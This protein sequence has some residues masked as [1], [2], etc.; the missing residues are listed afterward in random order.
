[1]MRHFIDFLNRVSSDARGLSN[2]IYQEDEGPPVYQDDTTVD[3]P[4]YSDGE[5]HPPAYPLEVILL[6]MT[7]YQRR[8]WWASSVPREVLIAQLMMEFDHFP[9]D[10]DEG[11]PMM[12][13]EAAVEADAR[14][15]NALRWLAEEAA[16][17][18]PQEP[19]EDDALAPGEHNGQRHLSGPDEAWRNWRPS[20]PRRGLIAGHMANGQSQ[21]QPEASAEQFLETF[22]QLRAD[23]ALPRQDQATR[24]DR[25]EPESALRRHFQRLRGLLPR[26]GLPHR[27]F[28]HQQAEA[29]LESR[30]LEEEMRRDREMMPDSGAQI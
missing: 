28:T 13:Q 24:P 26:R 30:Y 12:V 11:R 20:P 23:D 25:Q 2:Q 8:T 22:N 5:G 1:M 27:G 21:E 17:N 15:E 4:D 29:E 16:R 19:L 18:A 7:E 6:P 14:F 9:D 10:E 3:P